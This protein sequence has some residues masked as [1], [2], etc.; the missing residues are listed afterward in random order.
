MDRDRMGIWIGIG[1]AKRILIEIGT[2][3]MI[4]RMI[5]ITTRTLTRTKITLF[6]IELKYNKH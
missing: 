3:M 2:G 6:Y 1:I 5:K 4:R